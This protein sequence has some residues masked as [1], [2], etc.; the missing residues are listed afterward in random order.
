MH[1]PSLSPRT[2]FVFCP[3]GL[4]NRMDTLRAASQVVRSAPES[5]RTVVAARRPP[6]VGTP[7]TSSVVS[8]VINFDLPVNADSHIHRVGRTGRD[9][10]AGVAVSFCDHAERSSLHTIQRHTRQVLAVEESPA[11]M[12]ACCTE[13]AGPVKKSGI[14]RPATASSSS[15]PARSKRFP[16]QR[17]PMHAGR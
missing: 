15:R 10:A 9:G 5:L 14:G 6:P 2:A 7:R 1:S 4:L 16:S 3:T 8:H 17:R 11:G 12:A 13:V